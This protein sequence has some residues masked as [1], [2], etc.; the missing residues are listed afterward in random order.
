MRGQAVLW[1]A[2]VMWGAAG[3]VIAEARST[4]LD[5]PQLWCCCWR[6]RSSSSFHSA[7]SAHSHWHSHWRGCGLVVLPVRLCADG[8]IPRLHSSV[9]RWALGSPIGCHRSLRQHPSSGYPFGAT[10]SLLAIVLFDPM[11]LTGSIKADFTPCPR[12]F[13]TSIAF[14]VCSPTSREAGTPC[15]TKFAEKGS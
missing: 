8:P 4:Q 7:R 15:T 10:V 5:R 2:V 14:P 13:A 9:P 12:W 11:T 6:F 1:I 3:W